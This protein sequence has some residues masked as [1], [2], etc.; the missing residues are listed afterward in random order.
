MIGAMKTGGIFAQTT[1]E[2]DTIAGKTAKSHADSFL[3]AIGIQK[4]GSHPGQA[5]VILT[6]VG[7][8]SNSIPRIAAR[9]GVPALDPVGMFVDQK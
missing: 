4:R 6:E 5:C 8:K 7:G 3:I 1:V 2:I 9:H